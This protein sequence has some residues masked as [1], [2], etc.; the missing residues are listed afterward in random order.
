MD[1][2][3]VALIYWR[4]QTAHSS[5]VVTYPLKLIVDVCKLPS[6]LREKKGSYNAVYLRMLHIFRNVNGLSQIA[7]NA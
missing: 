6:N 2:N 4:I 5:N 3:T 7:T 1:I